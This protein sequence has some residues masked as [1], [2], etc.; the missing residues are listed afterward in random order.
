MTETPSYAE[1]LSLIDE[2]SA[3]LGAAARAAPDL[4]L[5]V[6][7]CPGWSLDDLAWH[8]AEVQRFWAVTVRLADPSAPPAPEQRIVADPGA[9]V[10]GLLAD[11]TRQLLEAL[12]AADPGTPA[13]AW[14]AASGAPMTAGAIAR[15]QV[16]EAAVHAFDAQEAIG[17]PEPLPAVV[18]VDGV[19]EF[20]SVGLSSLG[21]WPHGPARVAFA[22]AEG[23]RH[24]VDLSAGGVTVD[25]ATPAGPAVT[26]H[27]PASDLVL[28]LYG[29]T[30]LTDLPADGDR[31]ILPRLA[32]WIRTE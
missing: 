18:A 11:A 3:A 32:A 7:G 22:A 5:R 17:K 9:D 31:S 14:W 13:W 29:R 10:L 26:V 16:Q 21:G 8:L 6:P 30:A 2:R 27:A 23:P 28:A 4:R 20:L 12:R 24:L 15:H 1:L 25:P 19:A